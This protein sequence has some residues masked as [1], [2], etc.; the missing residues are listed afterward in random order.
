MMQAPIRR[1]AGLSK[2][3]NW[4]LRGLMANGLGRAMASTTSPC[5][6]AALTTMRA[7]T[8]PA[9][10]ARRQLRLASADFGRL[11]LMHVGRAVFVSQGDDRRQFCQLLFRPGDQQPSGFQYR[12]VKILVNGVLWG[13]ARLTAGCFPA[14]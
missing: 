10:V 11:D 6:P 8:G 13:L 4:P 12:Q 2:T 1:E 14:A 7:S 9:V 5:S 3:T